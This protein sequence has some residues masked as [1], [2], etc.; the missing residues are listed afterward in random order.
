MNE[1]CGGWE[2]GGLRRAQCLAQ[3][4]LCIK[5]LLVTFLIFSYKIFL[6]ILYSKKY[7]FLT[8][9]MHACIVG[10]QSLNFEIPRL[11]QTF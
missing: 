10:N 1:G 6:K 4:I 8:E 5:N 3:H 7:V 9:D 11:F 2:G